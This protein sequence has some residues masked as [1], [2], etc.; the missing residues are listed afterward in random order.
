MGD[1]THAQLI[2]YKCPPEDVRAFIALIEEY[3]LGKAPQH[4]EIIL[5]HTYSERD[6]NIGFINDYDVDAPNSAWAR[7]NDP[8]YESLG[9]LE[10]HVP[11]LGYFRASCDADGSAQFTSERI[12]DAIR[13]LPEDA[14]RDQV[15]AAIAKLT[16]RPW[17]DAIDALRTWEPPAEG[18]TVKGLPLCGYCGE[19]I[20]KPVD[21]WVHRDT[22]AELCAEQEP[23]HV[24]IPEEEL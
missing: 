16:G 2:V 19:Q 17:W 18:P 8:K 13:A 5:G 10:I 21:S 15:L 22:G 24:A 1:Y 4:D 14:D 3:G 23:V 12:V 20:A 9:D 6:V 11:E 7:W